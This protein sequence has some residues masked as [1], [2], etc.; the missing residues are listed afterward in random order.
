MVQLHTN[1]VVISMKAVL[2]TFSME[3]KKFENGYER[4]KFF[5]GLYGWKQ[6]VSKNQKRY[7]YRRDGL[8]DEIPHLRVDRSM[9]VI[10]KE[11]F[12]RMQ[13]FLEEWEDKVIWN[14][15]DVIL[16]KTQEEMLRRWEYE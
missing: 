14:K 15:F 11:H 1:S 13:R 4:N 10:M 8:L 12:D 9:F 6:I 7:V 2:I 5:R 16:D 3:T